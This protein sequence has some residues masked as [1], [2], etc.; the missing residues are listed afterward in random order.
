MT[1]A[2][3]PAAPTQTRVTGHERAATPAAPVVRREPAED[4][5]GS[6]TTGQCACGGGCPDCLGDLGVQPKLLVGALD[7]P[8]ERDAD[9]VADAVVGGGAGLA[10][11]PAVASA[12]PVGPTVQRC[13]AV[14]SDVCPCHGTGR[15]DA[16]TEGGPPSIARA[17]AAGAAPG[18]AGLAHGGLAPA[19]VGSVVA[20]GA[21]AALEP[22]L[23]TLMEDR[24]GTD[25]GAVRLHTDA[26]A[27]ASAQA[28]GARAYT[29]G[30][31]V[32]FGPGQYAPATATGLTTIAHE[33]AHVV[34]QQAAGRAALQRTPG[35]APA[36]Q[37]LTLE[38]LEVVAQRIA[39]LAI[40][41]GPES[42]AVNLKG[43]PGKV[44]SVVRNMTTG[45][46]YVGLNTGTPAKMTTL[47]ADAID[48]QKERIAAGH[49]KLVHTAPGAVGGHAEVNALNSAVAEH[50]KT[51]GRAMTESEIAA[52]FEMHNVWLAGTDRKLTTAPRCEHCARITRGVSVTSS[53][54]KVEG[55]VSGEINVPTPR[56]GGPA[57]GG[58]PVRVEVGGGASSSAKSAPAEPAVKTAIPASRPPA[59]GRSPIRPVL[60]GIALNVLLFV[61]TYYLNKWHAEKQ[62]RKLNNDLKR[63]LPDINAQLQSREPEAMEMAKVFPLLYGNVT[64]AY[65]HDRYVADEYNE[66]SMKL[67]AVAISHQNFQVRETLIKGYNFLEGNDPTYLLTF[68]VPLF[69]EQVAET[70]ASSLVRNY[71][72]VRENV[73]YPA[74]KV[75]LQ[76]AITL[77]RLASQDQSLQTLVVRDLLG[78][79]RDEDELVRLAATAFLSRLKAKIAIQYIRDVIAITRN[80][81]HKE[82]MQRYLRELE[83]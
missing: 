17:P 35:P 70:G 77:Y 19:L 83:Q 3:A 34:Q 43:G 81:K 48:A 69:E 74:Y 23:R 72:K 79:L 59:I 11:G 5:L 40:G 13:G 28:I 32:V 16:G 8:A 10:L 62:A 52:T 76:T 2:P 12:T 64:V 21:G 30:S 26:R 42:A 44:I 47:I 67:Q 38:S 58:K 6:Q 66:G 75:R 36:A 25:F 33:L 53:L 37:A 63:I 51:L 65:T 71:R 54:F 27:N 56:P 61:V 57:G 24:F 39:R 15:H 31:D 49:V 29:L 1:A 60:T 55:G 46:I 9:R 20:G 22:G 4:P 14:P 80:A 18:P 45:Q 78:L 73:T 50:G 41:I 82:M 7:D 68:S